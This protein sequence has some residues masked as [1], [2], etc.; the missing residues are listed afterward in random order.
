MMVPLWLIVLLTLWS[1]LTIFLPVLKGAPV[2]HTIHFA[3]ALIF[4]LFIIFN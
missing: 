1:G 2:S 4:C 3:V